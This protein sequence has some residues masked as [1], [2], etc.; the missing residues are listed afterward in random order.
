MAACMIVFILGEPA[1]ATG[2]VNTG[3]AIL[4]YEEDKPIED[5]PVEQPKPEQ[6]AEPLPETGEMISN[7][8]AIGGGILFGIFLILFLRNRR[9]ERHS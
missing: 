2:Q 5:S 9:K 6:P 8:S 4:F 3:G 7:F 1:H